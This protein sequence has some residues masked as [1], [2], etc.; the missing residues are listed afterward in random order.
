MT[1][2]TEAKWVER[3]REWRASGL[4]A[5][6]FAASRGY[7]ASTLCWAASKRISGNPK[8]QV[9]VLDGGQGRA[10]KW[11]R[12]ADQSAIFRAALYH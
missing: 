6:E 2:E 5:E 3:I 11:N 1:K 8:F 9:I 10:A 12:P 7:K 4:S